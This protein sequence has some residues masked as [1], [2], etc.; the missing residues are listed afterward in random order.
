MQRSR[1]LIG[2]V[3]ASIP[4]SRRGMTGRE[5]GRLARLDSHRTEQRWCL[6]RL[7]R[8]SGEV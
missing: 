4:A 8:W 3:Y 7:S 6:F 2:F 5:L 1:V